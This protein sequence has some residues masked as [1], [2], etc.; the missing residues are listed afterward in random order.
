[1][2]LWLEATVW[3]G[4]AFLASL[5]SIR[6][7][8]SVAMVEIFVG[9]L[10]GNLLGVHPTPWINALAAVGSVVLTFLA[11]AE[12][13]PAVLKQR[14]KESLTIGFVSFLLPFLAAMAYAYFVAGWSLAGAK[15]AGIALSTTSVAIVYAVMVE[16]GLNQ[17]EL[18]KIIL[19]ACFITDLGTVAALGVLFAHYNLWLL[20]FALAT[21]IALPLLAPL[22]RKVFAA[23][24]D[25]V[26]EPETK[27][28]FLVLF[29]LGALAVKANSEAVL[30][31]YLVGLAVATV[32]AGQKEFVRRLRG[33]AFAFLTPFYFLKAGALVSFKALWAGLGLIVILLAVKMA[34][35]LA[36]VWPLTA[37]FRFG[38]NDGIYTTL[39][40]S[41][42]LTF[43]TISSL[44]GLTHG[45]ID[46]Q[47]YSVL[48]TVVIL[49]GVI[50]TLI[51]QAFFKPEV[52]K[53]RIP[54]G[55]TASVKE[56]L[57]PRASEGG[58]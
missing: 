37:A 25:R 40:M 29:G 31:A 23:L 49:S 19:A 47:Q 39:L 4:L 58:K 13:E 43:G 35:K 14:W 56:V 16:T 46:R 55:G 45:Y 48:V 38:K 34:A 26:S 33:L 44:F 53:E 51:A 27:F 57:P 20:A 18:G 11:G 24:A 22:S 12:V 54:A 5:I 8:I 2:D 6:L 32:L 3:L 7:G 42:G 1:M 9:A 28:F 50:P 17:T 36:G 30:P 52:K 10:G 15:I 41:T 21:A